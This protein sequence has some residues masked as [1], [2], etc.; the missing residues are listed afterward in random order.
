MDSLLWGAGVDFSLCPIQNPY[1]GYFPRNHGMYV[2]ECALA[3]AW[4]LYDPCLKGM[5]IGPEGTPSTAQ[6]S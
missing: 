1:G 6:Q 5:Y 4:A 2:Q 3:N